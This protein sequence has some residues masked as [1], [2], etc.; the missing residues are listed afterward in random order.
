MLSREAAA[1]A[2]KNAG[3]AQ[4]KPPETEIMAATAMEHEPV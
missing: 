4:H 2:N 3:K 1:S